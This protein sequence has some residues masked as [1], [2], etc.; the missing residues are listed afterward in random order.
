MS[1]FVLLLTFCAGIAG[2]QNISSSITGSITDPADAAIAGAK[3]VV[4]ELNTGAVRT[5]TSDGRGEYSV[6]Q[7]PLGLYQVAVEANG[8]KQELRRGITLQVDQKARE[9]FRLQVG[10]ATERVE[11]TAQ[12]PVIETD[13]ATIGQVVTNRQVTELPL[14]GRD[15]SQLPLLAPSVVQAPSVANTG[16]GISVGG[17]RSTSNAFTIDGADMID[18][19]PTRLS[20]GPSVELIQEFKIEQNGYSAEF[21]RYAGGQINLTTKAGGNQFH[22]G[23]FE[24]VRNTALDAKDYFYVPGTIAPELKR[25]QFGGSIGGPIRKDKTFFFGA[26]EGTRLDQDFVRLV[27]VP[28]QA[29][30]SGDFSQL[31]QAGNPY[32]RNGATLQLKNPVTGANIPGNVFA[33]SGLTIDPIAA[34]ILALYPAPNLTGSQAAGAINYNGIQRLQVTGD[35]FSAR[36]DHRIN[37][38]S[39]FF[40]RYT[41]WKFTPFDAG[42]SPTSNPAQTGTNAVFF[43]NGFGVSNDQ[44]NQNIVISHTQIITPALINEV[45]ASFN[46]IAPTFTLEN[47][48]TANAKD[49][50]I[51]GLDP[52]S[53]NACCKGAPSL[54]IGGLA[55]LG[56]QAPVPQFRRQNTY[57]LND[58]ISY[59][60]GPHSLKLGAD[61]LQFQQYFF[62]PGAGVRGAFTFNG[63]FSAGS[64]GF[65][66]PDL[67][68]GYPA[69]S[70]RTIYTTPQIIAYHYQSSYSFYAQDDWKVTRDLTVNLGVRYDLFAPAHIKGGEAAAFNPVL[71]VIQIPGNIESRFDPVNLKLPVKLPVPVQKY[72]GDTLCE[73][74]TTNFSPRFGFAYRP[75]HNNST[76]IRGAYGIFYNVDLLGGLNSCGSTSLWSFAQSF[77]NPAAG[78]APNKSLQNPYPD[79][80]ATT[81]FSPV[82][83][84]PGFHPNTYMQ[85]WNFS[86]QRSLTPATV[87]EVRYLGSKGTHLILLQNINQAIVGA[88]ALNSRRPFNGLGFTNT[89]SYPNPVG[90]SSYHAVN[91][92]VER[93]ASIGLS[94]LGTYTLAKSLDVSSNTSGPASMYFYDLKLDHGLSNFDLRHRITSSLIYEVPFGKGRR[95]GSGS[96]RVVN[97][98]LGG[99]QTSS[100]FSAQTGFALTPILTGDISGTGGNIDRP[101]LLAD[102][103]TAG[104]V[105]GNSACVAPV[106][107]KTTLNW[108]NPCAFTV[109]ATGTFGN[110]ARGSISGPGLINLDISAQKYFAFT[111]RQRVEFRVEFFNTLNHPNLG[112]PNLTA[113]SSTF[114]QI[115]AT[116]TAPRQIQFGVRYSF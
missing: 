43:F 111:E 2:A 52:A 33:N 104:T 15:F 24:F 89:I 26:Y 14:N 72:G 19:G 95:F 106:Q 68:L 25:N 82:A 77:P 66:L 21:G 87:L 100:I 88:G 3:V 109:P 107:V 30:R 18:S 1:K 57:Q 110:A 34:K 78:S 64:S 71:G 90:N 35:Q 60:H 63:Q 79:A 28:T 39:Q 108:M 4:T 29:M 105:A 51:S 113:N 67:L 112:T 76:V 86:I 45:R 83:N 92:R 74:Q 10:S 65:G 6:L 20:L 55:P 36:V 61:L 75:L 40:A 48:D 23:A 81:S 50:G 22:G 7:I 85:Q 13:S 42:Q 98:V 27:A 80:L 12:V 73:T 93:R 59:T 44:M 96:S 103:L 94:L 91:L 8:F 31:L 114:A 97:G 38:N 70:S 17:A 115:T 11:V 16:S 54:T 99:W 69:T 56:Y 101:N 9:D 41:V 49:L 116:S 58:S 53:L 102:P 37:A 46:R 62:S 32:I 5:T 84:V 47:P